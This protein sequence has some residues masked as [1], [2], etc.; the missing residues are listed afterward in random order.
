MAIVDAVEFT[1][2]AVHSNLLVPPHDKA[3]ALPVEDGCLPMPEGPG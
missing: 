1:E 2:L 3:L